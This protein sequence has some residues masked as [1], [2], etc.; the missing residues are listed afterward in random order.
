MLLLL[1]GQRV[2]Q[3]TNPQLR[4]WIE[5]D[6]IR[7]PPQAMKSGREHI[8]HIGPWAMQLLETYEP[9]PRDNWTEPHRKFEKIAGI[10][11]FTRHDCRRTF[12]TGLANLDVD[13]HIIERL[14]DHSTG[15]ISVVG[16]IYNRAR[17]E[18]PM[19]EAIEKW[20]R[21][22]YTLAAPKSGVT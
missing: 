15:S 6:Q 11:P 22:L 3:M 18:K 16:K 2:G 5:G 4:E 13:P 14:L 12:A 8:I 19:R 21:H 10:A 7:F 20:D 9:K 1:T 17:Y